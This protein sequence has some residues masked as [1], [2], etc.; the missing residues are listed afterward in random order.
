MNTSLT[1]LIYDNVRA[2]DYWEQKSYY[3]DEVSGDHFEWR[4]AGARY[5]GLPR[6]TDP[7]LRLQS[8]R[9]HLLAEKSAPQYAESYKRL[10]VEECRSNYELAR[11]VVMRPSS[12]SRLLQ[13]E[14][15]ARATMLQ[16]AAHRVMACK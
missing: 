14:M 9:Q 1:C 5:T 7:L 6:G 11:L 3:L 4:P 2:S 8:A 16:S 13:A 12:R 10:S 15:L